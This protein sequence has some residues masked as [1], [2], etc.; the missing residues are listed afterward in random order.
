MCDSCDAR[1]LAG[2]CR[3]QRENAIERR[4]P[5]GHRTTTMKAGRLM[6]NL[7]EPLRIAILNS[8][9]SSLFYLVV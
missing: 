9:V 6:T 5:P 4:E 3:A 2:R 8:A 1:L 7:I